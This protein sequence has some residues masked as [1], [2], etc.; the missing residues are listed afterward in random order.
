M[1]FQKWKN[2]RIFIKISSESSKSDE[3]HAFFHFFVN[4]LTFFFFV[5]ANHDALL[6]EVGE[7]VTALFSG[8][9]HHLEKS[10]EKPKT[11]QQIE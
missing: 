8:D 3:F 1:K 9:H 6:E 11:M 5:F 7:H 10:V 4:N 2:R